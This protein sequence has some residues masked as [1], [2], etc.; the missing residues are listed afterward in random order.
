MARCKPCKLKPKS[1]HRPPLTIY[2]MTSPN[3]NIFCVTGHLCGEFTGHRWIPRTKASDAEL[4]CFLWSVPWIN[5]CV[6]NRKAGDL[7]R[8]HAHYDVIVMVHSETGPVIRFVFRFTMFIETTLAKLK[9]E[10][11]NCEAVSG[12]TF[13]PLKWR[14]RQHVDFLITIIS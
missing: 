11:M 10:S 2:M 13:E 9:P 1:N 8:Q 6:N 4:W 12:S 7:R 14:V 5:S 3:W